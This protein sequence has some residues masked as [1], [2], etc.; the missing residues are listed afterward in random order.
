MRFLMFGAGGQGDRGDNPRNCTRIGLM[1]TAGAGLRLGGVG[2]L[3]GSRGVGRSEATFFKL[4]DAIPGAEV[5]KLA[6]GY[7][8]DAYLVYE[9]IPEERRTIRVGQ[10][11]RVER[12]FGTARQRLGRLVRRT[13]SFWKSLVMLE[14]ALTVFMHSY[15]ASR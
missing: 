1:T 2:L 12:F 5:G 10:T 13:L 6:H 14:V 11:N 3:R 7:A 9:V 8:T 15:N 4:W